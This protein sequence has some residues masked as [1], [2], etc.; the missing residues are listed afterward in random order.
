MNPS[1]FTYRDLLNHLNNLSPHQLSQKVHLV[2][3]DNFA[4]YTVDRIEVGD[5]EFN[6]NDHS[7]TVWIV[8]E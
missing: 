1:A 4:Y 2:N 8:H 3:D 6:P 5:R 7:V